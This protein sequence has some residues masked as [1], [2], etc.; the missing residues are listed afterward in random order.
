M[1]ENNCEIVVYGLQRVKNLAID[2]LITILCGLVMKNLVV[3]LLFELAFISLRIY[4]GGYHAQKEKTCRIIS[5]V[6]SVGSIAVIIYLPVLLIL[7]NF[8]VMISL[9]CIVFFSPVESRNKPLSNMEKKV[10]RRRSIVIALIEGVAYLILVIRGFEVHSKA[11]GIAVLIIA[12]G[13]L[14]EKGKGKC[15]F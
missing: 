12:I 2:I 9:V 5:L 10:F 1:D 4:A 11:I 3:S 14:L 7:Q 8:M 6:S 15:V 13:L